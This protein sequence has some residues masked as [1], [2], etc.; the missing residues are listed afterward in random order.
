MLKFLR[1]VIAISFSVVILSFIFPYH[2]FTDGP[3]DKLVKQYLWLNSD[4]YYHIEM[5]CEIYE[6][7]PEFVLALINAESDG[8]RTATSCVGAIGYMQVMPYHV[9]CNPSNLYQPMLNIKAGCSYLSYCIRLSSGDLIEALKNYNAG[10][11]SRFYNMPYIKKIMRSY[12]FSKNILPR[13]ARDLTW[14]NM[15]VK[16]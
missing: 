2:L 1:R 9:R 12:L 5:Q 8:K 11:G 4:L 14:Y 7:D 3:S 16:L 10:P 6:L 13:A 15:I